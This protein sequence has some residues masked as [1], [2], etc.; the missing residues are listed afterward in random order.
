MILRHRAIYNTTLYLFKVYPKG[1]SLANLSNSYQVN[2]YHPI[3]CFLLI[4]FLTKDFLLILIIHF[5]KTYQCDCSHD[6]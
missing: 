1:V 2:D 4:I 3:R 6:G 5:L